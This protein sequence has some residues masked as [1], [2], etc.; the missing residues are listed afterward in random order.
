MNDIVGI[1]AI[2]RNEGERLLKCLESIVD[3]AAYIVY[4]DS[5]STDDSVATARSLGADVVELDLRMPFTAARAR[6]EGVQRLTSQRP[7][8]EFVQVV[9]GDCEV[10]SGWLALALH[11]IQTDDDVA[12]V[13]GQRR[14][15][16]PDASIYN[17]MCAMEWRQSAG[18]V[19]ACGGD[20]LIRLR[21][22]ASVN[23]YNPAMIAGEEPEMCF[24]LREKKWKI[25][26]LDADMTLHDAAMTE[27]KQF[28]KRTVRAGHAYAENAWR[29]G[30]GKPYHHVRDVLS[31]LFW[32]NALP[33]AALL[34]AWPTSGWSLLLLGG[35]WRLYSKIKRYRL[36]QGDGN[37]NAALYARMTLLSRFIEPIG[38]YKFL[39]QQKVLR[40]SPALIEYKS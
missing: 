26:N 24:R 10:I 34:G 33:A 30:W 39:I 27:F 13:C 29:H 17:R 22:F 3:Q 14:E 31:S 7:E 20:A 4:V 16:F 1:V 15:R 40:R 11:A 25:I 28:Y 12:V 35:Y 18:I 5:G 23:G 9:D 38:V 21:A 2:G 32:G 19:D 6:N 37:D 8:I 36:A